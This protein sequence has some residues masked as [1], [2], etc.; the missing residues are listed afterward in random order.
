VR[1]LRAELA[2]LFARR[3]TRIALV[4]VLVILGLVAFGVTYSTHKLND[5]D[6]VAAHLQGVQARTQAQAEYQKCLDSQPGA[7][8]GPT[9]PDGSP[10][11]EPSTAPG[12]QAQFPPGFDCGQLISSLPTDDEFLPRSFSLATAAPDLF[13]VLGALLALFGFAV[14]AS[15]IG[16]EWTSGGVMTLLLWRPRRTPLWLGKLGS[17][18]LGVLAVGVVFSAIWYAALFLLAGQRGSTAGMTAG[19]LRSLALT[20]A[21]AVGLAL[22]TTTLGFAISFLGRN[23]ATA[24]GVA[25]GW[26]VILEAAPQIVFR[27]ADLDQPQRWFL[28]TYVAAW[29]N[30]GLT[31]TDYP[32]CQDGQP[33]RPHIW[34]ISVQQSALILSVVV[35]LVAGLSLLTFRRRDVT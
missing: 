14:G 1:F 20:D 5:A 17:A 12:P 35:V 21:R 8:A 29:L 15:F 22:A 19:T 13:R 25:V 34:S 33:C 7:G 24:L 2:R 11:P 28:S 4:G 23:T 32:N 30:K 26:G 16:A 6:K 27:I 18:L 9:T 31:F 3:F 10:S